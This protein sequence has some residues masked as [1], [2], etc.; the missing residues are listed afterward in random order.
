MPTRKRSSLHV[1]NL[2]ANTPWPKK[3]EQA[4]RTRIGTFAFSEFPRAPGGPRL[5]ELRLLVATGKASKLPTPAVESL[6]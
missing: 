4:V 2:V 1:E 3:C 5:E 6:I